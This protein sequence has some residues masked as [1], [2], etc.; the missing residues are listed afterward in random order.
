MKKNFWF[1]FLLRHHNVLFH[2]QLLKTSLTLKQFFLMIAENHEKWKTF[3]AIFFD[4]LD[5][6]VQRV[7]DHVFNFCY[8]KKNQFVSFKFSG[9]LFALVSVFCRAFHLYMFL[10]MAHTHK[11]I[12]NNT[13]IQVSDFNF[14]TVG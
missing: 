13:Y 12:L 2:K 7:A 1:F 11:H 3:N 5:F 6:F 8:I 9:K 14:I 4:F 10:I